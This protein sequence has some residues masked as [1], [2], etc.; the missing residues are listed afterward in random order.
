MTKNPQNQKADPAQQ[1]LEFYEKEQKE[2]E[3]HLVWKELNCRPKEFFQ[4]VKR[5]VEGLNI[6]AEKWREMYQKARD[7]SRVQSLEKR[8][9]YQHSKLKLIGAIRA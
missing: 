4:A 2:F 5:H 6:P 8:T 9:T 1:A 7:A 3:N